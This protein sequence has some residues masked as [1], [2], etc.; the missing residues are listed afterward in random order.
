MAS[1]S[2]TGGTD[3]AREGAGA[4]SWASSSTSV[5]GRLDRPDPPAAALGQA[6]VADS[7][8]VPRS[9]LVAW[10][11]L[12]GALILLAYGGNAAA[13]GP[14]DDVLYRYA[15]ALAALVQYAIMAVIVLLISRGLG[16]ETLGFRPPRSW[17]RA[18]ALIGASL[19]TIW[20]G[21][22][23]FGLFLDAGEE[24]GLLPE[25]WDPARA[26][27]FLA[28]AAVIVL[29]APLVEETTYRGLGFAAVGS[30]F[31]ATAAVLVT[32]AAFG[33]SHGLLL[34]LPVLTLFGLLLGWLRSRTGSLYPPILLHAVFNGVA[35]LAAVTLGDRV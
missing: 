17:P 1:V 21:G 35:L 31:G 7:R 9:K 16:G 18:G 23:V 29:V 24:Q 26:D 12:V 22:W 15:T 11:L 34:A 6:A 19:A 32:G 13:P 30:R 4:A 3:R 5:S 2:G 10:A 25:S 20:A 33:L 27:A 28:N 8:V 14:P